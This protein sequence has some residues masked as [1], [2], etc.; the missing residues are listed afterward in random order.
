DSDS[1][2]TKRL[3]IILSAFCQKF[4]HP[5]CTNILDQALTP[6]Q[7]AAP[8]ELAAYQNAESDAWVIKKWWTGL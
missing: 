7:L 4:G 1:D 5:L 6:G 8:Q 2:S 3:A